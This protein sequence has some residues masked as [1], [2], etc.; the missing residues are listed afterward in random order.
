MRMDCIA[1]C[2]CSGLA[3][4]HHRP[5]K[6]IE[7]SVGSSA[8]QYG[9]P[10]DS[11]QISCP[12]QHVSSQPIGSACKALGVC[13]HTPF[14]PTCLNSINAPA[15]LLALLPVALVLLAAAKHIYTITLHRGQH[16][17]HHSPCYRHD[18]RGRQL[19][20]GV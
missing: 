6:V 1:R 10:L 13:M 7:C 4:L 18:T 16:I 19:P 12:I 9:V 3:A 14:Q 11:S 5:C 15:M 8:C 17:Q 20:E 2:N